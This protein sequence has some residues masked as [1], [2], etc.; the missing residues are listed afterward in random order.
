MCCYL[1]ESIQV[2]RSAARMAVSVAAREALLATLLQVRPFE[3]VKGAKQLDVSDTQLFLVITTVVHRQSGIAS[4]P[5]HVPL[6]VSLLLISLMNRA[7]V[8]MI[9]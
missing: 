3:D 1:I 2:I 9:L 7:V 6:V 4:S 5:T 8:G